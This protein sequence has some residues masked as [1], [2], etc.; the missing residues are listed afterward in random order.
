MGLK[1]RFR[2]L[3]NILAED[4]S[5]TT[6]MLVLESP[7]MTT[8]MMTKF[9]KLV[10]PTKTRIIDCTFPVPAAD[11][12]PGRALKDTL[13]RIK[14][15][16]EAAVQAGVENIVLTDEF[17]DEEKS[18]APIILCVGAVQTHLVSK[19][20]RSSC[21]ILVR[22][23][24]CLDTHY[25]AVLIGAGAT[26]VNAYMAQDTLTE[27]VGRGLLDMSA[28]EAVAQ[29]KKAIEGGLLKIISKMGISVISSYRGGNNFEAMGLSRALVGENFPGMT[30]RI[31][32]LYTS[33]SPR[34]RQKSRMPSSA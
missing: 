20:L 8:G 24:E 22:S 11:A 18:A 16:A 7:V 30:S 15:E 6:E 21:S 17:V 34:D 26:A 1:T 14:A 32:L 27:R 9:M 23:A 3:R 28:D 5:Q 25:F 12:V 10:G 31:C 19:G 33:P 29:Y 2:N 4:S 13:I